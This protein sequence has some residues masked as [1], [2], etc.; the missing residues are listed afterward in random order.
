MDIPVASSRTRN[1]IARHPVVSV[2]ASLVAIALCSA[3]VLE[4]AMP[5]VKHSELWI[6][7]AKSGRFTREV[8]GVGVL[9]PS[10]VRWIAAASAGR[11]ERVL[12]KPGASVLSDT[13]IAELSNPELINEL[14]RAR[15]D[16]DGA[17]SNLLALEAQ[18]QEQ[19]LERELLVTQASIALE[20]ARLK[21]KTEQPLADQKII[22]ALDFENTKLNTRLRETELNIRRQAQ[23]RGEDVALAKLAAEQANVRR[24]KNMVQHFEEQMASLKITADITGVLQEISVDV[25]QRVEVGGNI[26][27]VAQPDSLLAELQVQENLVQDLRVGLPVTVDTRNGLVEGRIKRIDPRVRAGNVQIDVDL[28]SALPNGARP[29]LSV[30]GTIIAEEIKDALYIDRP[31]GAAALTDARLFRLDSNGELATLSDVQ[32]G[33]AS[34]SS[35]QVLA[36]LQPGDAVIVSDTSEFNQHRAVR[37]VQ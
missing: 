29:D 28:I 1:P 15:W 16:L 26:A 18:L 33:K 32:F 5:G 10:E 9:V 17:E 7:E 34:V 4:P 19:T 12:I 36:G 22:S 25:G 3:Y 2:L 21:Q 27:R 11:V 37:I 24:Y 14:E 31:A 8:R 20:T 30:T 6:S 35:I 13:V 23:Q